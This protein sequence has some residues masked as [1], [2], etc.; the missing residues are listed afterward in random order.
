MGESANDK[1]WIHITSLQ[2]INFHHLIPLN[3]LA[4]GTL[5]GLHHCMCRCVCELSN[6]E[7]KKK[8]SPGRREDERIKS[9]AHRCGAKANTTPQICRQQ[10]RTIVAQPSSSRV[11][12]DSQSCRIKGVS[13]CCRD[14]FPSVFWCRWKR[15]KRLIRGAGS[16]QTR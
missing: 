16:Q 6:V 15:V 11:S 7:K 1:I 14:A 12:N 4:Y 5:R 2:W 13:G 3:A 9:V 8:R 10:R